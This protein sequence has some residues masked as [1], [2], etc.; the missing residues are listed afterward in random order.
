MTAIKNI[1]IPFR[2]DF[3]NLAADDTASFCVAVLFAIT[4][5]AESQAFA[6]TFLGDARSDDKRRFHFNPLFHIDIL[7]ILC[8]ALAGFGWPR[9]VEINTERFSRPRLFLIL[10]RLAGPAAN[11]LMANIAL[12]VVWIMGRY[13]TTDRVFIILFIVNITMSVYSMLPIPP[14]AG[15]SLIPLPLPGPDNKKFQQIFHLSGGLVL[16]GIVLT[17]KFTGMKILSRWLD[18]M[19]AA[20]SDFLTKGI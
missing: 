16:T 17:E 14:L 1:P 11:L 8:F 4:I 18:P 2:L 10:S 12:S 13:G 19:V 6:A 20:L 15:A 3:L 7:G 5:N 9:T